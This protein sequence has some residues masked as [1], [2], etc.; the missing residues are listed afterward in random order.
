MAVDGVLMK[1]PCLAMLCLVGLMVCT[2]S[3]PALGEE[4]VYDLAIPQDASIGGSFDIC[5][6]GL[7]GSTALLFIALETGTTQTK[8]GTLCIKLPAI[9]LMPFSIPATGELCFPCDLPCSPALVGTM[10]RMVAI[11]G[12]PEQ[13]VF[14]LTPCMD[15]EIMDTGLCDEPPPPSTEP[16][17]FA[18]FTQGGWGAACQGGNPGCLLEAH[19]DGIFPNGLIVGDPDGVDDDEIYA[20]LLTSP[21]AVAEFLPEG[22]A[23]KPF[24]Q[25]D[26]NP[27]QS[28]AGV[29]GG[30]LVAAKINVAFDAAGYLD[31]LKNDAGLLLGDMVY[32]SGVQPE[33]IGMSINE[34]IA[35]ADLAISGDLPMP[36]DVDDDGDQDLN[37][38]DLNTAVELINTNFH[39]GTVD[40]GH[41]G[42]P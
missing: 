28:T 42:A 2:P 30:Q 21:I 26:V 32:V 3:A 25:D 29:L 34:L 13:G 18:T 38:A 35:L 36:A 16:G 15:L 4:P 37:F 7:P 17:D 9:L 39:E 41:L 6:Q 10:V 20:L 40:L 23:R 31:N 1:R 12:G 8:F 24:S 19:F 14:G 33:L 11:V 27:T 22:K 5:L